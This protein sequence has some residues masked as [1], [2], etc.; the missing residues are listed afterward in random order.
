MILAGGVVEDRLAAK[1]KVQQALESGQALA[2][3]SGMIK[4]QGGNPGVC[5][6]TGILPKASR[7]VVVRADT[8]GIIH[9]VATGQIGMSALLLGAG[10]AKKG[11]NVDPAVGIWMHVREGDRVCRG[12]RLTTFHVND[13]KHLDAAVTRFKH[14]LKIVAGGPVKRRLIYETIS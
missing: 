12:D 3:L 4:A 10:R 2:C 14:S 6:N 1:A 7:E 8:S 11:D 9:E 13:T 5:D